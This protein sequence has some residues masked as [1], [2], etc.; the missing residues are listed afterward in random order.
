MYVL[1]GGWGR[2]ID[3]VT[4]YVLE[5]GN[6][7][8]HLLLLLFQVDLLTAKGDGLSLYIRFG[9]GNG[10]VPS[11]SPSF[12]LDLST[13]ERGGF[14]VRCGD[15]AVSGR[16]GSRTLLSLATVDG[17]LGLVFCSGVSISMPAGDSVI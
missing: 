15:P 3:A 4:V 11:P 10:E 8:C 2:T 17:P 16:G 14:C 1:E 12:L 6:W 9:R 7:R 13:A 5:G